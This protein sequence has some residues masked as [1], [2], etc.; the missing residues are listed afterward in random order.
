M[1]KRE[2]SVEEDLETTV[3][4][5]PHP[6]QQGLSLAGRLAPTYSG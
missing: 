3:E 6:R 5:L 2:Y 4:Y 1:Q